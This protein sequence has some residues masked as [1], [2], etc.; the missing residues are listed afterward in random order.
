VTAI[1][2]VFSAT[3]FREHRRAPPILKLPDFDF[4]LSNMGA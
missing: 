1:H 4:I 2:G 3:S